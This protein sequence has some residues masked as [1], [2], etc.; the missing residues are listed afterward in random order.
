L[1]HWIGGRQLTGV[2]WGQF[3]VIFAISVWNVF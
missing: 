3:F 1:D 2:S